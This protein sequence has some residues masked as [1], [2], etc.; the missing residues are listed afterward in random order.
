[1]QELIILF[2]FCGFAVVVS[3]VA[4]L[5]W[6]WWKN[7]KP[8]QP[9]TSSP[10][11][12]SNTSSGS[13]NT[14]NTSGGGGDTSSGSAL[15]GKIGDIC[16]SVTKNSCSQEYKGGHIPSSALQAMGFTSEQMN[17][18]MALIAV[19]EN[20]T[21]DWHTAYGYC[22]D[23]KAG[24]GVTFNI[25][26][27]LTREGW[28]SPMLEAYNK[29]AVSWMKDVK[30]PKPCLSGKGAAVK[31]FCDKVSAASKTE[32]WRT[33]TWRYYTAKFIA[34]VNTH[35]KK[36]EEATKRKPSPLL[37]ALMLDTAVN[38]GTDSWDHGFNKV[39][40]GAIAKKP[41]SALK[42]I[43]AWIEARY[44]HAFS[45]GMNDETGV[46]RLC[47][48]WTLAKDGKFDLKGINVRQYAFKC[49]CGGSA[50]NQT[51][52]YGCNASE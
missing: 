50:C 25:M 15:K 38:H 49:G 32:K 21:V 18:C 33:A 30:I 31:T 4:G 41:G 2:L 10:P 35:A 42:D 45:G 47:Q 1:M 48:Y 6:W 23:N 51:K 26:G 28:G 16:K 39:Y 14:G 29:S 46:K 9:P 19:V 52:N 11:S 20:A 43:A 27:A 5:W 13:G 24:N 36:W 17:N 34:H 8:T 44:P 7:D 40:A 12:S 37:K 22:Q 3:A